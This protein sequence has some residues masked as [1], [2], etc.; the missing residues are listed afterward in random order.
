MKVYDKL[1]RDR[2][3]EIIRSKGKKAVY[4]ILDE[5]EY[6]EYLKKKLKEEVDEFFACEDT[7]S[8]AEEL[9]DIMTV[10]NAIARSMGKCH[11][12][13]NLR[14]HL[15]IAKNGDFE[16]RICLT[17]VMDCEPGSYERE[18]PCKC[19]GIPEIVKIFPKNRQDC[20]IRCTNCGL[21]TKVYVCRQNAKKAWEKLIK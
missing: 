3:P 14:Y 15:K 10:V 19:G 7:E 20:F 4:R 13:M 8:G 17:A 6:R 2:I 1:V 9:I 11:D 21:E 18:H 5:A 12:E 16:D